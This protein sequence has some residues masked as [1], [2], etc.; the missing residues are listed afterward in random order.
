[1]LSLKTWDCRTPPVIT[2]SAAKL[3]AQRKAIESG[4]HMKLQSTWKQQL[5]LKVPGSFSDLYAPRERH[6][7]RPPCFVTVVATPYQD[8]NE[9]SR[10]RSNISASCSITVT[11]SPS[12]LYHQAT[13][14]NTK[15]TLSLLTN[16]KSS[17]PFRQ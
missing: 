11:S 5:L 10:R 17:Q 9:S 13:W 4:N 7:L 3:S 2:I 14:S 8:A 16:S 6:N 15:L 1:M 12:V